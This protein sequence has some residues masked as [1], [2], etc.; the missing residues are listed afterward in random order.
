M[1][2]VIDIKNTGIYISNSS[3]LCL[4]GHGHIDSTLRSDQKSI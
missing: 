2:S 3:Q 4:Y 1:W